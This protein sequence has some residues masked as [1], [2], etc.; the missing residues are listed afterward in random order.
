MARRALE[1]FTAQDLMEEALANNHRDKPEGYRHGNWSG[2]PERLDVR[3]NT[4]LRIIAS[5]DAAIQIQN[6]F[7]RGLE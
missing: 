4:N 6:R 7:R 3:G 1:Q 5:L 2:Q